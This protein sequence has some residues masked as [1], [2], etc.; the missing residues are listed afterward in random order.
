MFLRIGKQNA[1]LALWQAKPTI[2]EPIP[3]VVEPVL[4]E[5]LRGPEIEPRVNFCDRISLHNQSISG[6]VAVV[7]IRVL[8]S[9]NLKRCLVSK[10]GLCRVVNSRITENSRLDTAAPA[11][12]KRMTTLSKDRRFLVDSSFRTAS[13]DDMVGGLWSDQLCHCSN[14]R[15]IRGKLPVRRDWEVE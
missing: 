11:I 15:P 8:C 10:L 7:Y 2:V 6:R 12:V 13:K 1:Q 9:R 14:R 5:V 4:N 3:E